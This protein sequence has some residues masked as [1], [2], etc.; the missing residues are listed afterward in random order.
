M[1]L[2]KQL[3][4]VFALFLLASCGSGNGTSVNDT[5]ET[6]VN[7]L[8]A[9]SSFQQLVQSPKCDA[10]SKSVGSDIFAAIYTITYS[11]P[12]GSPFS[13]GARALFLVD[14]NSGLLKVQ[15]RCVN[16]YTP[17]TDHV[18][19]IVTSRYKVINRQLVI[20]GF[21]TISVE[22]DGHLVL[23]TPRSADHVGTEIARIPEEY[24]SKNSNDSLYPFFCGN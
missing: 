12:D 5:P 17:G 18:E 1:I 19:T 4:G 2:T 14:A 23:E 8:R 21:G 11:L 13:C 6:R 15:E 3:S 10:R 7:S 16:V 24:V 22:R 20:E 9:D